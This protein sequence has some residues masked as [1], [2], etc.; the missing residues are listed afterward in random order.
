MNKMEVLCQRYWKA[1]LAWKNIGD[2]ALG[3]TQGSFIEE[4]TAICANQFRVGDLADNLLDIMIKDIE[5]V[6]LHDNPPPPTILAD[7]RA[8]PKK[9]VKKISATK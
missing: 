8:R 1:S 2:H 5:V 4:V 6:P 7:F 3:F 9:L